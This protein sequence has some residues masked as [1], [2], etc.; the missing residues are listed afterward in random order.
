MRFSN[1]ILSAIALITCFLSY[2]N[3]TEL[4]TIDEWESKIAGVVQTVK[5]QNAYVDVFDENTPHNLPVGIKKTFGETEM[6]VILDNAVCDAKGAKM[7]AYMAI[8]FAGQDK[9]IM[10][11]ADDVIYTPVGFINA[12]LQL[13]STRPID[14]GNMV[15]RLD[16]RDTYV[17]FDCNGYKETSISAIITLPTNIFKK[18]NAETREVIDSDTVTAKFNGIIPNPNNILISATLDPFQIAGLD[19]FSFYANDITI[20]LSDE[21]NPDF[22]NTT[23]S[24]VNKELEGSIDLWRGVYISNLEMKLPKQF[25]KDG[26]NIGIAA[27]D[28]LIDDQGITGSVAATNVLPQDKGDLSGWPISINTFSLA[29]TAGNLDKLGFGGGLV[30]PVS[31]KPTPMPY[32]ALIDRNGNYRFSVTPPDKTKFDIWAAEVSIAENSSITVSKEEKEFV[33]RAELNGEMAIKTNSQVDVANVKFEKLSIQNVAPNFDIKSFTAKVGVMKG[34]PIQ[35]S[36]I[37]YNKND[38]SPGLKFGITVSLMNKE[39]KGFGA[40]GNFTIY[41]KKN[42]GKGI[43]SWKYDKTEFN[44]FYLNKISYKAFEMEGALIMYNSDIVYGDGMKGNIKMKIL[45]KIGVEATAQFGNVNGYKYWYADAFACF[46]PGIPIFTAVTMNGFG[47]GAFY[48]MN[49]VHDSSVEFD[50]KATAKTIS[51]SNPGQF[52]SGDR[53]VPDKNVGIGLNASVLLAVGSESVLNVKAGFEISFLATGGLNKVSFSGDALL[54]TQYSPTVKPSDSKMYA[55]MYSEYDAIN[56]S[57][58]GTLDIYLN[59]AGI[60]TGAQSGN[61]AGHGE[62]YFDDGRWKVFMGTPQNPIGI[63]FVGIAE[64]NSYFVTGNFDIP[65]I[66]SPPSNVSSILGRIDY[67]ECRNTSTLSNAGGFAFGASL[68]V[69]MPNREFSIFYGSFGAGVGFDLML[70]NY[71]RNAHCRGSSDVLGIN[72]W[73]ATGQTYAYVQGDIGMHYKNKKLS[74]LD[75]SVATILEAQLP[76]PLYMA[77]E[78]GGRYRV[79]GGLVKGDCNFKFD[80]G[81]SC[82][83]VR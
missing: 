73:Y 28:M 41:G 63:K 15:M 20:D 10:F 54:L 30:L 36:N 65:G 74:I 14:L 50:F 8:D 53:Y 77:G 44:S 46:T 71:G 82:D 1:K 80:I 29:F 57:F 4:K 26:N 58:F 72:G 3:A 7:Q 27:Y 47:G 61:Y 32:E 66:P 83:V 6:T 78:V 42:T 45:D 55:K 60:L 76:N 79:L 69:S 39:D 23:S 67:N 11:M 52:L 13:V 22:G 16:P 24:Y 18:E 56:K 17:V 35:I 59:I 43:V 9:P 19:G 48:H 81:D 70:V 40:T 21:M 34:F 62:I 2:A 5:E 12:K 37:G 33:I 31:E 64:A 51:N 25:C 75:I 68:D 49:H 38:N